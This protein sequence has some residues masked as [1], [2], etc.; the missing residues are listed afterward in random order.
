MNN[1]P[2]IIHFQMLL[3]KVKILAEKHKTILQ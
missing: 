1:K 2:E 3:L